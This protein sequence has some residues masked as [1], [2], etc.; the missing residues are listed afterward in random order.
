VIALAL[1]YFVQSQKLSTSQRALSR[2]AWAGGDVAIPAGKFR[3]LVNS[4]VD[5]P[6]LIVCV[7]RF[8]ANRECYV[9]ADGQSSTTS[10]LKDSDVHWAEIKIVANYDATTRRFSLLTRVGS[11]IGYAGGKSVYSLR[12]EDK[13]EDFLKITVKPGLYDLKQAVEISREDGKP[14]MLTVK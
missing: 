3:L 4:I 10:P 5:D 9:S 7:I 14:V 8:E 2:I 13:P 11:D 12:P 1:A 6:D